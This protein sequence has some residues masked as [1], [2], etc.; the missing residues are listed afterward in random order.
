MNARD[1]L[2]RKEAEFYMWVVVF[3]T[4]LIANLQRFGI[5]EG[6]IAPLIVLRDDF[7]E[8]Y[9]TAQATATRTQSSILAKNNAIEALKEAVRK[10]VREYL[11]FNHLVTDEDRTNMGLPVYKKGHTPVPVPATYPVFTIDSSIIR[12][13]KIFFRDAMDEARRGKPFGVHGAEIRWSISDAPIV[14]PDDLPHSAF[15]T[16]SPF[17]LEFSGEQRGLTVWF[18]LRWEN[19]RGEKG[20]WGEIVSAIIP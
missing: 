15:D 1:Y 16:R 14:N 18:C 8:K 9:A 6:V 13:L 3:F 12:T 2:P 7:D 17:V 10:F 20:P 19:T 4:Y 5:A 11:A